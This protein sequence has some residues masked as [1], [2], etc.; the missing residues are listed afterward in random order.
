MSEDYLK[1]DFSYSIIG[2]EWERQKLFISH[3]HMSQSQPASLA[4]LLLSD[5]M[6][7]DLYS[8]AC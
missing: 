6:D 3:S 7:S 1:S 5:I 4:C 2:T 8:V